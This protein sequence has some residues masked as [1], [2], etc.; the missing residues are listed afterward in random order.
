M[1]E[2]I[3]LDEAELAQL[4]LLLSP[5]RLGSLNELTGNIQASISLHQRTLRLGASLMTIIACIEIAL[6]NAICTNLG[7]H[8]GSAGWLLTPPAPFQWKE[9]ERSKIKGAQDSARR[10]AYSKLSQT[11][12]HQLDDEAFPNG[13]P[14]R[15]P[16]LERAKA[17]R[18]KLHVS[19][20]Q[21]IAQL[22]FHMWK[23]LCGPDYEHSLW[24]PS[25]KRI[26]P[27]KKVKR[28]DV[29]QHLEVL[30]Q[31]RNRLAHHEP[32]LHQRFCEAVMAIEFVIEHLHSNP[33]SAQTPLARL[34]SDD[35]VA[36]KR[37]ADNLHADLETYRV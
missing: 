26:F 21:I 29:S 8:F 25:L 16:H 13:R 36:L 27:Y 24:K 18:A 35:I 20:G 2:D 33:P 19:D 10:A 17:R 6:R 11:E 28:S 37:E 1:S 12:K 23:R 5:E 9:M 31:V 30:Y 32:V 3:E 34:L 4:S 22:T 15:M 14:E 7:Q